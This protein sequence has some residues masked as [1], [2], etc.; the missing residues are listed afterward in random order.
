M[1]LSALLSGALACATGPREVALRAPSGAAEGGSAARAC[2]S[3]C[4]CERARAAGAG[5]FDA[6]VF[7]GEA[8]RAMGDS[9]ARLR[10]SRS[11]ADAIE[12]AELGVVF[13]REGQAR[14]ELLALQ[15]TEPARYAGLAVLELEAYRRERTPER[16][17]AARQQLRGALT[18]Q[19]AEERA[20]AGMVLL[21]LLRAAVRP[22]DLEFAD[23]LC[24][25][26]TIETASLATVC[27]RVSYARR[28][29]IRG[30]ELY[31]RAL[32]RD[33]EHFPA[34]LAWGEAL[35]RVNDNEGARLRFESAARARSPAMRYEALLG[36][37]V[38]RARLGER[39]A[40]ERAYRAA[41]AAHERLR[42]GWPK[43][44]ASKEATGDALPAALLFNLGTLL[45]RAAEPEKRREGAAL[46]RR[47]VAHADADVERLPR[48]QQTLEGLASA[49][50]SR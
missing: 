30:G 9:A 44:Q 28:D 8:A 43:S 50:P 38:A 29:P 37:G 4:V 26:R 34:L 33:P 10:S 35:L 32:A 45:A 40:A 41:W 3:A 31:E 48:V 5:E 25:Q 12:L 14:E 49:V 7:C 1:G 15:T 17:A 20:L 2:E 46:L 6:W 11:F 16:F 18:E 24:R 23:V 27:A 22:S 19:A 47:Y 42:H 21:Y 13:R 39:D 36:L